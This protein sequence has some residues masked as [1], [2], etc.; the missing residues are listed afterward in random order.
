MDEKRDC[1]NVMHGLASFGKKA[2]DNAK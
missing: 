1:E 2:A